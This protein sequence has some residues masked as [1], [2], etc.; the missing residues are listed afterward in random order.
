MLILTDEAA[1]IINMHTSE[2]KIEFEKKWRIISTVIDLDIKIIEIKRTTHN[3][4]RHLVF[5]MSTRRFKMN[6][7][8]MHFL[9]PSL[10]RQF[11][12]DFTSF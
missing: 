9:A 2:K 3:R 11:T 12:S 4:L 7:T 5:Q 1:D 10:E 8:K 6:A